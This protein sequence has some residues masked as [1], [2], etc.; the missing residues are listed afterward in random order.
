MLDE[1]E[2]ILQLRLVTVAAE[3]EP[4]EDVVLNIIRQEASDDYN[5]SS[6]AGANRHR[7]HED[8]PLWQIDRLGPILDRIHYLKDPLPLAQIGKETLEMLSVLL[9]VDRHMRRL[10]DRA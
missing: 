3:E 8:P 7:G 10:T 4:A 9:Y 2:R 5:P 1:A 6:I